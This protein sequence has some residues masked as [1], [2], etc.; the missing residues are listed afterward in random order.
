MKI[1]SQ[2]NQ[3]A[4]KLK[5]LNFVLLSATF[6]TL[7]FITT[8]EDPFNSPKLW[9]LILSGSWIIGILIN[10][11]LFIYIKK[12]GFQ[13][14]EAFDILIIIFILF[15]LAS[16]LKTDVKYIALFGDTQRRIGFLAYLFLAVFAMQTSK[17]VTFQNIKK[18][19]GFGFLCGL[20]LTSY[21]ILQSFGL[22]FVQWQNPYNQI[23]GT[24]GNPN[25]AS[26]TMAL[27]SCLSFCTVFLPDSKV[28]YKILALTLFVFSIY[29]IIKSNSI[30]GLVSVAIG[31]GFFIYIYLT[32]LNKKISV[33]Y[34]SIYLFTGVVALLGMLQIGPMTALVYKDSVSVRGF[35]WRAGIEMLKDKIFSGVGIDRYGYYFKQFRES[36]YS[37]RYGFEI[38]SSNAHNIPIQ[39]FATGGLFVGITYLAVFLYTFIVGLKA[40]HKSQGSNRILLG[41]IFSSWL[42]YW[43]QSFISIEN[44]GLAIWGWILTGAVIGISKYPKLKDPNLIQH[45]INNNLVSMKSSQVLISWLAV[46]LALI[47]VSRLYSVEKLAFQARNGFNYSQPENSPLFFTNANTLVNSQ[48]SDPNYKLR[49]A[50]GLASA[51]K[52]DESLQ[53]LQEINLKDT[54]NLDAKNLVAVIYEQKKS[55]YNA[56]I[57]REQIKE[58]DPWNASNLLE[59][60]RNYKALE[61]YSKMFI[62]KSLILEFAAS[63][64]EGKLAEVELV[65]K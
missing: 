8:L 41:G 19:Y 15:M 29:A 7:L 52:L 38:T 60:A 11:I 30:Q 50:N 62:Q 28:G 26:A 10:T 31:L 46:V 58:I 13:K 57:I 44:I 18:L 17:L 32:L 35:Y 9:V 1:K 36:E 59:L 63:T 42:V 25:F 45:K 16:T 4:E 51:G 47:P 27:F 20:I 43:A 65:S 3:E 14:L 5:H 24:L 61:D 2:I 34:L 55:F 48:L 54:R 56:A 39:L 23:L 21:G 22:D 37:L 40:I 53:I 49:M 64:T 6:I 33:L 12:M